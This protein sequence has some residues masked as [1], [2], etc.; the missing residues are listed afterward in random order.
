MFPG[1][2]MG[3]SFVKEGRTLLGHRSQPV[4]HEGWG[5]ARWSRRAGSRHGEQSKGKRTL[6]WSSK[7]GYYWGHMGLGGHAKILILNLNLSLVANHTGSLSNESRWM[8]Q[9]SQ[10]FQGYL[11]KLPPLESPRGN[12]YAKLISVVR[13]GSKRGTTNFGQHSSRRD[14]E[15]SFGM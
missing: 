2:L 15:M 4:W 1:E 3:V 7:T 14:A 9:L 10:G 5:R 6:R 11:R 13:A 8:Q 12:T